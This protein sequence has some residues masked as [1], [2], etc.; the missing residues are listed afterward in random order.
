MQ[1]LMPSF[2]TDDDE[3]DRVTDIKL[4]WVVQQLACDRLRHLSGSRI[5]AATAR[6][7]KSV[8]T[9]RKPDQLA[10]P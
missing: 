6:L 2:R 1:R 10:V 7:R 3:P 9:A 8:R 4:L 5:D